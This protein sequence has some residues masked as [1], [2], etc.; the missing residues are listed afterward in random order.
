VFVDVE[1]LRH[2]YK[3]VGLNALGTPWNLWLD[4]PYRDG[5]VAHTGR[6]ATSGETAA[7]RHAAIAHYH[8]HPRGP[9]E[10]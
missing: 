1:Q 6:V 8:A 9:V 3:E 5:G 10:R 7:L 4:K 2:N